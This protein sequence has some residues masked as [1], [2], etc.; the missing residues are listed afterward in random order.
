MTYHFQ[1][2]GVEDA[3]SVA[4]LGEY[5]AHVPEIAM[6]P[7]VLPGVLERLVDMLAGI[8]I[9]ALGKSRGRFVGVLTTTPPPLLP[10]SDDFSWFTRG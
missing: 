6:E 1:D 10:G 9:G 3:E 2:S 7:G 4:S 8:F 5:V